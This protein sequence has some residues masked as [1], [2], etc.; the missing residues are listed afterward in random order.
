[1][2]STAARTAPAIAVRPG[3]IGCESEWFVRGLPLS[4]CALRGRIAAALLQARELGVTDADAGSQRLRDFDA[5]RQMLDCAHDLLLEL[6]VNGSR[7]RTERLSRFIELLKEVE[8]LRLELSDMR[9]RG[10]QLRYVQVQAALG[11]LRNARTVAQLIELTPAEACKCGFDRVLLSR[12]EDSRW[13]AQSCHVEGDPDLAREIVRAAQERVEPLGA[14]VIETEMLRRHKPIL[15]ED[16]P[17][18]RVGHRAVAALTACRSYVAAPI[19]VDGRVIGFL[20]ADCDASQRHVDEHDRDVL[21]LFADVFAD[22]LQRTE[23]R[24]RLDS[25]RNQ[26]QRMTSSLAATVDQSVDRD[27]ELGGPCAAS[28]DDPP[29][30]AVVVPMR[31]VAE[32]RLESLLTKRELEVLRLMASGET[33]RGIAERLVISE[34]TVKSHVKHILR[35]LRAVNRADAASRFTRI[36]HASQQ[37]QQRRTRSPAIDHSDQF[38][39]R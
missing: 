7:R 25:L 18:R 24:E 14:T 27:T 30:S 19:V 16:A 33:N 22:A 39:L 35:K 21:W 38:S 1:M 26:I 15:V 5:A 28:D 29:S 4:N 13:Y 8:N 11:R 9:A 10:N 12:V 37:Q 23:L 20:H 31:A 3:R 32:A 36:V 34:G 17:T 6:V 2:L